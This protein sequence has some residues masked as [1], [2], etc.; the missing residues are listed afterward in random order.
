LRGEVEASKRRS[1]FVGQIGHELLPDRLQV[2]EPGNVPRQQHEV[3]IR[4]GH[5]ADLQDPT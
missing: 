5:R 4:K 3:A 1:N 2:A